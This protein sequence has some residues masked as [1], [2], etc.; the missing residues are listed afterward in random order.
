MKINTSSGWD[1]QRWHLRV[2][3]GQHQFRLRMRTS[4]WPSYVFESI[5]SNA[6]HCGIVLNDENY[7]W[8]ELS[9]MVLLTIPNA[10]NRIMES[11]VSQADSCRAQYRRELEDG[12]ATR[13]R[14][15][16]SR[17]RAQRHALVTS[18]VASWTSATGLQSQ[19]E[20]ITLVVV[21]S[22]RAHPC[23]QVLNK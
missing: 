16:A 23:A 7:V 1:W 9:G 3:T 15:M 10:Q 5:S 17:V 8:E 19:V 20:S 6:L 4:A 12:G 13:N 18:S 11:G 21:Q 22:R 2:D 14:P